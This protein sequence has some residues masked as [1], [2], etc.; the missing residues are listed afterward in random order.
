MCE[1]DPVS[2]L[3]RTFSVKLYS[4]L[5]CPYIGID[6]HCVYLCTWDLNPSPT[7]VLEPMFT[8]RI[9]RFTDVPPRR[10]SIYGKSVQYS[11][12][13]NLPQEL[14]QDIMDCLRGDRKAL[15]ACSLVCRAWYH[16][17]R[18][19]LFSEFDLQP[20]RVMPLM[21]RAPNIIPFIRKLRLVTPTW[22]WK[23][24]FCFLSGFEAVQSL[25]ISSLPWQYLTPAAQTTFIGQF[26]TVVSL[27]FLKIDTASFSQFAQLICAFRCLE[28]LRIVGATWI[29]P[30]LPPSTLSPPPNLRAMELGNLEKKT[31]LQW[32]AS[33]R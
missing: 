24:S 31:F 18:S 25:W 15:Y 30:D 9:F 14:I 29:D 32:L 16:P 1:H 26:S 22:F 3:Y 5:T 17:A 12:C 27:H 8:H 21:N 7:S 23:K 13:E 33:F 20:D 10:R 28:T 6:L 2:I 4:Q 11:I 19:R